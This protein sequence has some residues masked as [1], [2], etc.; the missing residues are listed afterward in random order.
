MIQT[1]TKAIMKENEKFEVLLLIRRIMRK[2]ETMIETKGKYIRR[3]SKKGAETMEVMIIMS[4]DEKCEVSSRRR[5]D[6]KVEKIVVK[7]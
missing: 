2:T 3:M 6:W 4:G 1:V 7:M 5:N